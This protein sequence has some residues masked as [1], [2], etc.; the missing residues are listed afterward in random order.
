MII[1]TGEP[2]IERFSQARA[3]LKLIIGA[4]GGNGN[5]VRR[6]I[7]KKGGTSIYFGGLTFWSQ[8]ISISISG[9]KNL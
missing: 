8:S 2:A 5:F 1:T 3:G 7:L 6:L 9:Q 4:R